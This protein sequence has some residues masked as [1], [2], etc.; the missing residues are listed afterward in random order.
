MLAGRRAVISTA[1]CPPSKHNAA[2]G[3]RTIFASILRVAGIHGN[4]AEGSTSGDTP[5][6]SK[7]PYASKLKTRTVIRF[8]GPDV[9]NFLQGLITNDVKKFEDSPSGGTSPPSVNASILYHPP[10]YTAMLNS[11]GRFLYDL[12]L[13]KPNV[14]EEKLDRTGSGPGES[15][16]APVLL[17]DVDSAV[18]VELVTYLKKHILR[19]KVQVHDISEDLSVWQY[20]GGKLAEHP[21]N[22]T[23]SEGGAIGYGGTKDESASSS[24]LVNDNQWRWYKDPRLSTLGLRGLFSKHTP[25]PLVE[26]NTEVEEDYYLL[27]RLE[28]GVAEGSTEIPKGEAIP[29]E[30]NLAG[31]NAISFDKGCYVGQELVART[32]HRGVI[33]KRL[34]PLSFTDTNGK[35]AQ[36]AVAVGAEV[37]D[38][39]IG[40]KVGKVSTV[41]GPRALGMIRLESAREGNNQLCIEN[42]HD[43]LVKAVR[44]K[45]W[46]Q[47]WGHEHEGL[48]ANSA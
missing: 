35:E 23:E 12:F 41:L 8:D 7:G 22:T 30:Y 38:K 21:S 44:P 46:P 39:R 25:P 16:N 2:T 31:L 5:L 34:M 3:L 6:A 36:A 29:L 11:Q 20:Y 33:R 28:Q 19:K 47:A 26:A 9:L 48:V 13:Y 1:L 27:W 4:S 14:E 18:A 32:H 45:W 42:Q 40:K 37:L 24:V 10:M 15:R 43:I 17:A